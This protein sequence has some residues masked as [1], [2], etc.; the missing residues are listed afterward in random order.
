MNKKYT[1]FEKILLFLYRLI[2]RDSNISLKKYSRGVY[3]LCFVLLMINISAMYVFS[4]YETDI[5]AFFLWNERTYLAMTNYFSL[6]MNI[7]EVSLGSV[8][9][10]LDF[11]PERV[12]ESID[13]V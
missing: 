2:F 13:A 5:A 11:T 12:D 7:F 10:L 4:H 9:A 1:A 8:G 6:G 3:V